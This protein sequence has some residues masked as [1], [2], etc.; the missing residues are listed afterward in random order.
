MD[1]VAHFVFGLWLYQKIPS[2]I[3]I[4]LS[5]ILDVDHLLGFL[6]DKRK[7][8]LAHLPSLLHLAYRPRSWLHSIAGILV[9]GL[10]LVPFYGFSTVFIPLLTHIL[11]D[12][13]D[14][15]GVMLFFPFSH[16]YVHGILPA[17]YLPEDQALARRHKASHLPSIVLII[18]VAIMMFLKV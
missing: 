16:K 12:M 17:S 7:S 14:K 6:Y 8:R 4:I 18:I 15:A 13:L 3:V 10:P 9:I 11:I 5:V 1:A 2:P